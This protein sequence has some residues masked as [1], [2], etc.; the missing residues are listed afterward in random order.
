MG[1]VNWRRGLFRVWAVYSAI[2]IALAANDALHAAC[3]SPHSADQLPTA[4]QFFEAAPCEPQ[5]LPWTHY[6]IEALGPPAVTFLVG[7]VI[8]WV[9][10]GF[11]SQPSRWRWSQLTN[12]PAYFRAVCIWL[13]QRL[14]GPLSHS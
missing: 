5:L 2:S 10:T 8:M 3:T 12:F 4:D 7:A 14:V 11:G 1:R 6:A 13:Y 9:L